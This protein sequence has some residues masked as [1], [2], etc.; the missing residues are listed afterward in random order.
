MDRHE[1]DWHVPLI[2][3]TRCTGCG[4][5]Q[6]CCPTNAVEVRAGLAVVVRPEQCTFCERCERCCP[7]QAIGRPFAIVFAAEEQWA[8]RCCS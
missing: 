8:S 5:C 1:Q 4:T 3:A 7:E 6:A 2:D